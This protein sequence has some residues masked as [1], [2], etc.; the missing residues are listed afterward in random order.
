MTEVTMGAR[1]CWVTRSGTESSAASSVQEE[2][3]ESEESSED[4]KSSED[5]LGTV[6]FRGPGPLVGS[7]RAAAVAQEVV[8]VSSEEEDE[9]GG[10]RSSEEERE[11]E[12]LRAAYRQAQ[13]RRL[14]RRAVKV[15]GCAGGGG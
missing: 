5:E 6:V 13:A 14:A 7:R 15:N 10:G 4:G 9:D 12:R 11:V 3:S 1:V 2:S 8:V